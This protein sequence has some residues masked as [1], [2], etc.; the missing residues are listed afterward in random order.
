MP[1]CASQGSVNPKHINIRPIDSAHFAQPMSEDDSTCKCNSPSLVHVR[2]NIP[3]CSTRIVPYTGRQYAK[4]VPCVDIVGSSKC[5]TRHLATGGVARF[6]Y[7][8]VT[9]PNP[10][11]THASNG[12]VN[13]Y[14]NTF[15]MF[16]TRFLYCYT[17]GQ[18]HFRSD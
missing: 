18:V 6:N 3:A 7:I 16:S 4:T 5:H 12:Q 15:T 11:T 8:L 10:V 9:N 13:P 14:P 2:N 17:G 1:T